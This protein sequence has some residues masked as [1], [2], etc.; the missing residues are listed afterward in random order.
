MDLID[1]CDRFKCEGDS[2][3]CTMETNCS[4]EGFSFYKPLSAF[5]RNL[6]ISGFEVCNFSQGRGQISDFARNNSTSLEYVEI[7]YA[8]RFHVPVL[9]RSCHWKY[10]ATSQ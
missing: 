4:F 2:S 7:L 3:T 10:C 6:N 9:F 5:L 8:V 1:K